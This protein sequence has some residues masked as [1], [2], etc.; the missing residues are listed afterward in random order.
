LTLISRFFLSF[1]IVV[2]ATIGGLCDITTIHRQSRTRFVG[3]S[4]RLS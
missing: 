1:I 2:G 3:L 4:V